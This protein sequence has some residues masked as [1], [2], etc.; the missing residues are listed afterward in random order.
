VRFGITTFLT[1]RSIGPAEFAREL[2]ARGFDSLFLPEHTHI[3]VGRKTPAPMGEPLP[4]YYHHLLDP[5]VA[6]TAAAS[7]SD[8]LR[9][10]TGICLVAQRDPFVLAKEVATL[11]HISGGRFLFG[12]G[13]GW[14]EDEMTD[15]GV[16]Y[17]RRRDVVRDKVLAM[18]QLW[19]EDEASYDGDAV[20]FDK[21]WAW[22]KPVQ[23]PWPPLF[24]GGTGGPR[25]FEAIAEYADGWIPI[26]GRGVK[27]LLPDLHAALGKQGRDP[28][29]IKIVPMGTIPDEG[30][31]EHF[32]S[33]GI[34]EIVLGVTEGPRDEMLA[35]LDR[36]ADIVAPFRG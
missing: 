15:H 18:Q 13:F 23:R 8:Q 6:L 36:Y 29:E 3:P 27:G 21:S 5:F 35:T 12:I 25:L 31:V 10:G 9:V 14:N 20:R 22:P 26:G 33:M 4:D 34:D 32:R 17:A 11:D 24:I 28:S 2:D 16:E 7:A 30:K 19:T 1:D